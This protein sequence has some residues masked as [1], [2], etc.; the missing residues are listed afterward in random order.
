ME[1]VIDNLLTIV[2]I[3]NKKIKKTLALIVFTD[4]ILKRDNKYYVQY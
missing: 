3:V 2:H 4:I 1:L